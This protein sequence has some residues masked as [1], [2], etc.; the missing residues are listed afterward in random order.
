M[1]GV[2]LLPPPPAIESAEAHA[3]RNAKDV[4]W[5]VKMAKLASPQRL[6]ILVAAFVP[7]EPRP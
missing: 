6:R 1:T 7:Q 2:I 4:A 3:E 5:C